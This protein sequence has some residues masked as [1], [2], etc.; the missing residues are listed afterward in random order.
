[1][2][3]KAIKGFLSRKTVDKMRY[4]ELV[5]LGIIK[6]PENPNDPNTAL[7]KMNKNREKM[8]EIQIQN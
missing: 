8:R 4:D 6:K 1:M 5:F 2:I 3:Q 7:Y